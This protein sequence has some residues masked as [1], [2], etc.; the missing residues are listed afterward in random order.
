MVELLKFL[1]KELKSLVRDKISV[2]ENLSGDVCNK[3]DSRIAIVKPSIWHV[4]VHG[5]SSSTW[6]VRNL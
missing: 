5:V 2:G 1:S 3:E 6:P 4:F